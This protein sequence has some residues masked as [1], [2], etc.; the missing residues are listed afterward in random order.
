MIKYKTPIPTVT[1]WLFLREIWRKK[2][3]MITLFKL[4]LAEIK[5]KPPKFSKIVPNATSIKL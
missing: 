4:L 5:K 2:A 3:E 1:F